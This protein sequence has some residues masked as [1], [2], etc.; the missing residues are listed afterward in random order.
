M[1]SNIAGQFLDIFQPEEI[2][3]LLDI[4]TKLKAAPNTGKFKAFTNGFQPT[5]LIYPFITWHAVKRERTLGN[6]H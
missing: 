1:K 3:Q 2:Q 4:L 6:T 5:D